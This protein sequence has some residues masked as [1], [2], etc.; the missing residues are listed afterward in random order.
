M[1]VERFKDDYRGK[2]ASD[3]SYEDWASPYRETLHASFLGVMERAVSGDIGS[4]E[5]RWRL[6]VGQRTLAIDPE[7]DGVE[8]AVIRAVSGHWEPRLQLP[9]NTHTTHQ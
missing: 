7:A 9:S 5:L 4:T 6:W 2:F 8:A 1:T 3:F